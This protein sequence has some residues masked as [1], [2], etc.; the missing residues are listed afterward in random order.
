MQINRVGILF[1]VYLF[2]KIATVD[3]TFISQ[4]SWT[5]NFERFTNSLWL[6]QEQTG[7]LCFRTCYCPLDTVY[8]SGYCPIV[9]NKKSLSLH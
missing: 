2:A 8:L 9:S 3:D 5:G 7:P 6:Y 1:G 4:D